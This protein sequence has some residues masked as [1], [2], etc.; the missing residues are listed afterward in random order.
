MGSMM[1]QMMPK[2]IESLDAVGQIA[3]VRLQRGR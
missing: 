1:R 2:M 3:A